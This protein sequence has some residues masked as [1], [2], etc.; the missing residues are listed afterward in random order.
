MAVQGARQKIGV[1]HARAAAVSVEVALVAALEVA[2]AGRVR[3]HHL[4]PELF[5]GSAHEALHVVTDALAFLHAHAL[6]RLPLDLRHE[7]GLGQQ[8]RHRLEPGLE[9]CIAGSLEH[10]LDI[11]ERGASGGVQSPGIDRWLLEEV[12]HHVQVRAC[13]GQMQR[14]EGGWRLGMSG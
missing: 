14:L 9:P 6:G 7:I 2:R 12:L 1:L 3:D 8:R 11:I 4:G 5:D 13:S 10:G